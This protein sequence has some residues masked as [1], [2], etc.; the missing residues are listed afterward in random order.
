MVD[1]RCAMVITDRPCPIIFRLLNGSRSVSV[2]SA[3]VAS[4]SS[5]IGGSFS[6]VRAM[7]TR[8]FSPP[9][10]FSPARPP[11]S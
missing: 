3:L 10:S 8:C 7:P 1:S 5:R 6:S 4:S 11:V 9:D 2:S